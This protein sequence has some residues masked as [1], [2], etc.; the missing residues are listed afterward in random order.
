M[1]IPFRLLTLRRL[2]P[3]HPAERS[4][5][6]PASPRPALASPRPA[7]ASPCLALAS[8]LPALVL[9]LTA[10]LVLSAP[11]L[12]AQTATT[13]ALSGVIV[14]VDGVPLD[15]VEVA[16]LRDGDREE[17]VLTAARDGRFRVG[18]LPPGGYVVVAERF[19][20]VPVRVSAVPIRSGREALV[21]IELRESP[22][23]VTEV[24]RYTFAQ[25]GSE[26][27]RGAARS[28]SR[29]EL[30]ALPTTGRGLTDAL[31]GW[32]R[33]LPE[34]PAGFQ[35]TGLPGHLTA[36]SVDG[37]RFEPAAHPELGPGLVHLGALSPFF[38]SE[39]ELAAQDVDGE[40][41]GVVGSRVRA[42]TVRGGDHFEIRA[43][44]G[45]GTAPLDLE[46]R[47]GGSPASATLP[48]GSLLL[49]GPL[50]ADTLQLAA[51]IEVG[52]VL[53][54]ESPLAASAAG[55][56]GL[57]LSGIGDPDRPPESRLGPT[58]VDT[59]RV[60]SGFTRLDWRVRGDNT[61][62][63]RTHVGRATDTSPTG[64]PLPALAPREG[65]EATDLILAATY[66]AFPGD[67]SALE[68]RTGYEVSEREFG[69]SEAPPGLPGRTW[70]HEGGIVAGTEPTLPGRFRQSA[71]RVAPTF[72]VA[73]G[74][75]QFK[76]GAS[77]A[78]RTVEEA[79][80]LGGWQ[81]FGHPSLAAFNRG[82]GLAVSVDGPRRD[83]SF[84]RPA[85]GVFI[86][87]RW[88]P[89]DDLSITLGVRA[90]GEPLP[91]D[92][93][94]P[95]ESWT[96]LT[97]IPRERPE[98]GARGRIS[99]RMQVEWT[100]GAGPGWR[101]QGA[102][103]IYHGEV[104]P[105]ILAELLADSGAVR[106]ERRLLGDAAPA[107]GADRAGGRSL[108]ILGPRFD[109]PRTQALDLEVGR[110]LATGTSL[111]V[112]FGLRRTDF[113][114][115]RRDLN[116]AA[117]A[118][119]RDQLGRELF[120]E[121]ARNGSTVAVRPGSDRRF[122]EFDAVWALESDGHSTWWGL[123]AALRHEGEGPLE[124]YA[125]YTLSETRDNLPG[126]LSGWPAAVPGRPDGGG[127]LD[128]GWVEGRSDR[129]VPHRAVARGSLEV[130]ERL[131]LR[132][133]A[134]YGFHSGLPFTPGVR[135]FLHG[136]DPLGSA[137][138]VGV[139]RPL[140]IPSGIAGLDEVASRWSCVAS[141]GPVERNRCRTDGI[142][143]LALSLQMRVLGG[144]GWA[145]SLRAEALNL[146]DQ[147]P[148]IPDAALFIVDGEAGLG[149]PSGG[150]LELPLRVN[151]SFGE[152]LAHLSPGR[153]LRVGFD[154][155]Y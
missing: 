124:L 51:G 58:R 149:A 26:R 132:V 24:D 46:D 121:V 133:G 28:L 70:I 8:R 150:V 7:P 18:F 137:A 99:P 48:F 45:A 83:L 77:L 47:L 145:L 115:R 100:P 155:R 65:F 25:V 1:R 74:R 81:S 56:R 90:D 153:G 148:V 136:V 10:V 63:L 79:R 16:L 144:P 106:V 119:A 122:E 60:I 116:R 102:A 2:A 127:A 110:A 4:G 105:G 95:S 31:G 22:P 61:L 86:Q 85:L 147:G 62:T 5:R 125:A 59:W 88:N 93:I 39:V 50:I 52:E 68:I 3:F 97:G 57:F 130:V 49:R 72:Q 21:R 152:P 76:M 126:G 42:G 37:L 138:V 146:L 112:G 33:G 87:D 80:T 111:E 36:V 66:T 71:F 96:A 64:R 14:G 94:L 30:L 84:S 114:P 135:D 15:G 107:D 129:D 53:R 82:E 9:A 140:E 17:R 120:G 117:T 20:F 118:F 89:T 92:D 151:P 101:L 11:P 43:R 12:H 139:G 91:F 154:L 69:G 123:T 41:G 78:A 23:P 29:D 19:G 134:A 128:P 55:P 131:G 113:L 104:H 109:A 73:G 35:A 32:S 75:H 27:T 54:V 38:L 103:G 34:T 67:R 108:S 44:G 98:E 40:G 142:H 13:G 143:D 6:S 141:G